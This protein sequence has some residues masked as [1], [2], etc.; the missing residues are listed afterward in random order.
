[1]VGVAPTSLPSFD[2]KSEQAGSHGKNRASS[3]L[4]NSPLAPAYA[5]MSFVL[6]LHW[7]A[8]ALSCDPERLEPE[9][10]REAL[11]EL[12]LKLGLTPVGAPS[13][14]EHKHEGAKTHAE[15]DSNETEQE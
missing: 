13:I 3:V 1:M 9:G 8:D 11:I 6:G 7:V 4:E 15:D 10:V 14:C 12:P 5:S 2:P